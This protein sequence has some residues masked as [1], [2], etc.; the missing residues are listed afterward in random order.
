[1]ALLIS[2]DKQHATF[3]DH[4]DDI[5]NQ[6]IIISAP[7]GMGK[8][9]FL[10]NYFS[11]DYAK[12]YVAIKLVPV[13]YSIS[14]NDDIFRLIKYDILIELLSSQR[15]LLDS[16]KISRAIAYGVSLQEKLPSIINGL[17]S[18]L[19]SLNKDAQVVTSAWS[20]ISSVISPLL[21]IYENIEA[22]R[23]DPNLYTRIE[24][25]GKQIEQ[26]PILEADYVTLFIEEALEKLV[27]DLD[28][29]KKKVLIIDDLDR[30]DP[31][32]I[33]RLFNIF[34]THLDYH[35]EKTN[36]FGFDKVIFVCDIDNIRTIFH[37]RYGIETDFSGY[38]DKFYSQEIYYFNNSTEVKEVVHDLIE[39]FQLQE[40][41]KL[42]FF[43][44]IAAQRRETSLLSIILTELIHAGA[45]SMRRL[46]S[47]YGRPY[48][49]IERYLAINIRHEQSKSW[50]LPAVVLLQ[51]LVWI[52][53]GSESLDRALK[54]LLQYQRSNEYRNRSHREQGYFVGIVLPILDYENHNFKTHE[55]RG[56]ISRD[57]YVFNHPITNQKIAYNLF[58]AGDWQ[59]I[60]IARI[61]KIDDVPY[62]QYEQELHLFDLI[63]LAFDKLNKKGIL[64]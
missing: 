40:E 14:A 17:V 44:Y 59:N 37:T 51:L 19:P 20:A 56:N 47:V 46:Q 8:T 58:A 45:L 35:K 1:M 61:D 33:F 54:K 53:G 5:D 30:I 39:S 28:N 41:Y 48:H 22:N 49:K 52:V 32:H 31:E 25:F 6:R 60:Y 4:I 16:I 64:R 12:D 24:E 36:K 23:K 42:Y 9:Y 3:R 38:I 62:H 34:S 29:K 11:S 21:P 63:Y 43:K 26:L 27:G 13:N 15:L 50:M 7:F 57:P 18:F 10:D 2:L 55:L